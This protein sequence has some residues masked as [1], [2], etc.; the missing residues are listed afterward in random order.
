MFSGSSRKRAIG[1]RRHAIGAA[2]HVEVVDVGR[3]HVDPQRLEDVGH[4]HAQH[5]RLDA[6]DIDEDLRRAGRERRERVDD[7]GRSVGRLDQVLR[8]PRE[9][10]RADA[11]AILQA[12]WKSRSYRRRRA[13]A[14]ARKPAPSPRG[15]RAPA[16]RARRRQRSDSQALVVALHEIVEHAENRRHIRAVG[17]GRAR[18]AGVAVGVLDARRRMEDILRLLD[19]LVGPLERSA[20][21]KLQRDDE[22]AAVERRDEPGRHAHDEGDR[23]RDQAPRRQTSIER[24]D[25]RQRAHERAIAARPAPRSPR[26]KPLKSMC[27]GAITIR[28]LA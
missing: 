8:R 24:R 28:G 22:D 18:P 19:H 13:R 5:L 4:R 17:E 15:C 20:G 7:A 25:T 10:L 11:R 16:A 21:R 27:T 12:A 26:L 2:E 1:L 3:A 23:E 9:R 14:E 6:I